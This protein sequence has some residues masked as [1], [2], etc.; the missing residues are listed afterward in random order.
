M[1]QI[2]VLVAA[3]NAERWLPQCLDSLL[4]QTLQ[5]IEI[6]CINDCST[7]GTWTMLSEYARRDAR[8]RLLQ[9]TTNSGQAVARNLGLEAVTAP[10]VCMVD[11]DDWLSNDALASAISVFERYPLTD[12]VCF[13]LIKAFDDGAR[14]ED[15]GLPATLAEGGKLSGTEAARFSLD[16]WQLHGLYV[17]RTE[18]HRRFPFD[19]SARLYSD[20]NATHLH[21]L[22][23][24]EVRACSGQYFYRQ[25]ASLTHRFSPL[26]FELIRANLSLRRTLTLEGAPAELIRTYECHRWVNYIVVYR[27]FLKHRRELAPEQRQSVQHLFDEI[28]STFSI[29]TLPCPYRRKPGYW[30]LPKTLFRVEQ[31]LYMVY[32]QLCEPQYIREQLA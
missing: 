3:Y 5:D 14:S 21:Y 16:G 10:Y 12:S 19:T 31:Y 7:D 29:G 9:T 2:A 17:T 18:L 30:L 6:V 27:T 22:H 20:D 24:R 23:S 4:G 11:A 13:R 32:K 26:H 1:P 15:Y 28:H 25:H 8:I